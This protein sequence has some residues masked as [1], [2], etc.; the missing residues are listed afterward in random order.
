MKSAAAT[1]PPM[2]PPTMAGV[3]V[4]LGEVGEAEEEGCGLDGEDEGADLVGELS[5][6]GLWG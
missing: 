6:P 3:F 2:I 5:E 1:I 4:D